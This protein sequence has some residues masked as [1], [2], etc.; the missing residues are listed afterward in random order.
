MPTV[1]AALSYQDLKVRV[2]VEDIR[3]DTPGNYGLNQKQFPS[4]YQSS[5]VF[6]HP[7]VAVRVRGWVLVRVRVRTLVRVTV[8]V[9]V[10]V[11]LLLH[12]V[13]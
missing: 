3:I 6:R 13:I 10:R 5:S 9:R 11:G 8:A 7:T 1:W 4:S 12:L 2:R